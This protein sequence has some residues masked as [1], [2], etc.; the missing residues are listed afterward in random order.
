MHAGQSLGV[1]LLCEDQYGN[2][3]DQ[4]GQLS[5]PELCVQLTPT[6]SAL[7]TLQDKGSGRYRLLIQLQKSGTFTLDLKAK[8]KSVPVTFQDLSTENDDLE[9]V[10]LFTK[11]SFPVTVYPG[12]LDPA[13]CLVEMP[14]SVCTAGDTLQV[15]VT[16]R[17]KFGNATW[18]RTHA[19][20]ISATCQGDSVPVMISES[21]DSTSMS[22]SLVPIAADKLTIR[23][24]YENVELARKEVEVKPGAAHAPSCS[25]EGAGLFGCTVAK[26]EAQERYSVLTLCDFLGNPTQSNQINFTV[27]SSSKGQVHTEV[28]ELSSGRYRLYYPVT[29]PG[30]YELLCSVEGTLLPGFPMKV[31]AWR[32]QKEVQEELQQ[33]REQQ[34]REQEAARVREEEERKRKLEEEQRLQAEQEDAQRKEVERRQALEERR[35]ARQRQREEELELER[36]RRIAEKLRKYQETQRRAEEALRTLESAHREQRQ[37]QTWKRIGGGFRVPFVKPD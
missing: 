26:G 17:D 21:P 22:G 33:L 15:A 5:L 7:P 12:V 1:D 10:D 24:H 9:I 3:C 23:V 14:G 16:V 34:L 11:D 31:M 20:T 2:E 27:R 36:R 35:L 4:E 37:P 28:T 29:T 13:K 6:A 25:V 30:Q 18:H 32:D 8:N 19:L